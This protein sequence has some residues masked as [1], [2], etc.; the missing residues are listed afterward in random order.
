MIRSCMF[1][2]RKFR[3]CTIRPVRYIPMFSLLE[4]FK[5]ELGCSKRPFPD[6]YVPVH[7]IPK[8][9]GCTFKLLFPEFKLKQRLEK[10][11][12]TVRG[13]ILH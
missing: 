7:F 2:P 12:C 5:R 10:W 4:H 6:R 1:R 11:G 9:K 8:G 3:L 13:R